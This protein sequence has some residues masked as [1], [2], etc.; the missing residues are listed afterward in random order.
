MEIFWRIHPAREAGQA[1]MAVPGANL[2][3]RMMWKYLGWL[4]GLNGGPLRMPTARINARQMDMA[5]RGLERAGLTPTADGNE[6]FFVG[7]TKA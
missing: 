1:L 6:L 7:R 2:A 3:Q 5:R 4:N